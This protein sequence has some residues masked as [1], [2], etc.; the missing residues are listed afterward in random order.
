MISHSEAPKFAT[1]ETG[2]TGS[3]SK[4]ETLIWFGKNEAPKI[5]N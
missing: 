3:H 5:R 2:I 4:N 1:Q